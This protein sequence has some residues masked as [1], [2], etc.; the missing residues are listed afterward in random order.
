MNSKKFKVVLSWVVIITL[1]IAIVLPYV[2]MSF[3]K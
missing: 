2:I 1:I 3:G